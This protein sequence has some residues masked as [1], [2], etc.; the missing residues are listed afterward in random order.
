MEMRREQKPR[1]KA[2]IPKPLKGMPLVFD[3][4]YLNSEKDHVRLKQL[5]REI[6]TILDSRDKNIFRI[7]ELLI[8][9]KSIL[10]LNLFLPWIETELRISRNIVQRY[11]KIAKNF[12]DKA[13]RLGHLP[14]SVLYGLTLPSTP[15]SLI[16][17]ILSG[18]YIPSSVD[19]FNARQKQERKQPIMIHSEQA[20]SRETTIQNLADQLAQMQQQINAM[21][22]EIQIKEVEVVPPEVQ[23]EIDILKEEI[24]VYQKRCD[25]LSQEIESTAKEREVLLSNW[26]AVSKNN[27]E[28]E[29]KLKSLNYL[30]QRLGDEYTQI[31]QAGKPISASVLVDNSEGED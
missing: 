14:Y 20:K 8:N 21:S 24:T 10:P 23:K 5:E 19:E 16:D 15:Q 7:G 2:T 4:K 6:H 30:I 17:S 28:L 13:S 22:P 27:R 3:Y 12:G 29:G 9:A 18:E 25:M 31:Y 1:K 11:M 26:K